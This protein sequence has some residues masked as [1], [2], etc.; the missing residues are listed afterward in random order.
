MSR[1]GYSSHPYMRIFKKLTDI[2]IAC[3]WVLIFLASCSDEPD[4]PAEPEQETGHLK[5]TFTHHVDKN[6]IQLDTMMY[7]NSAGNPYEIN[8]IMY[9]ISDVI[10]Y[11][12]GG[13][14]LLIDEWNSYLLAGRPHDSTFN[15]FTIQRLPGGAG[16][17]VADR[18][19]GA[20]VL[21]AARRGRI[22]Q[23]K[24]HSLAENRHRK[25]KA[26]HA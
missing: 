5:F 15:L 24:T 20:D 1:E 6:P 2:A 9:F 22:S 18:R 17:G 7:V 13:Q 23:G 26:G 16:D 14:E 12:S 8:E 25:N 3:L 11:K 19:W 10:L 4:E 21:G